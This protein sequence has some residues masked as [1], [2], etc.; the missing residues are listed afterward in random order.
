MT[1]AT[2]RS[3]STTATATASAV[4]QGKP[5]GGLAPHWYSDGYGWY[6]VGFPG[7]SGSGV[8]IQD[9]RSAG[10]FTHIIIN[11]PDLFYTPGHARGHAHDRDPRVPRRAASRR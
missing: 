7:D 2:R 4:A 5:E 9:N 1:A 6:G 8:T 3:S 10:N 11:D